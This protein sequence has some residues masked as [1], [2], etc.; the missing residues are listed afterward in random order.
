[1]AYNISETTGAVGSGTAGLDTWTFTADLSDPS[2]TVVEGDFDVT[3]GGS[4]E[5]PDGYVFGPLSSSAFGTLSFNTTDGTF[6]FTIDRQ[7]V[8]QSGQDQTISFSVTGSDG[9]DADTDTVVIEILVCL[10]RGTMVETESG[11]KPVET[12]EVGDRIRTPQGDLETLRWLGKREISAEEIRADPSMRPVRIKAGALGDGTPV[13]DLV[14]SPQHRIVMG[15]VRTELL[16]GEPEVLAPAIGLVG[17][18]GVSVDPAREGVDYF[19]LLFDQHQII[20]TN[21]AETES[22]YPGLW[23]FRLIGE[24]S[25]EA[26]LEQVPQ[27]RTPATYGPAARPGLKVWEARLLASALG[28]KATT[29][30]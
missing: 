20:L 8:I 13:H 2:V 4:G 30:A 18:P 6:T 1:M 25:V 5:A 16:F 26:L 3:L 7:A 10:A 14:V 17:L 22:F 23:S 28:D 12:L 29:A 27:A 19:H 9:G 15:G 24:G 21:G 11:P